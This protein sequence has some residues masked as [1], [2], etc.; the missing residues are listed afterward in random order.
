MLFEREILSVPVDND[1]YFHVLA[2][3]LRYRELT[4]PLPKEAVKEVK[5]IY[6]ELF[7]GIPKDKLFFAAKKE[8]LHTKY[9]AYGEEVRHWV[10]ERIKL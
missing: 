7:F 10:K 1:E 6:D 9:A 8:S 5:R 3:W 2:L 4:D